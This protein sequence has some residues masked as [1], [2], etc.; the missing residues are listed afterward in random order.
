MTLDDGEMICKDYPRI[1]RQLCDLK[2]QQKRADRFGAPIGELN[3]FADIY[4]CL[5][6][7]AAAAKA[8][9]RATPMIAKRG[10]GSLPRVLR[11]HEFLYAGNFLL[12][13]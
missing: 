4:S 5:A 6:D 3:S 10:S 12:P 1:S 13:V 8:C 11:F 9:C 2:E 7:S